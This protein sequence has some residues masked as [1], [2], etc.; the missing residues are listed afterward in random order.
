MFAGRP[1]SGPRNLEHSKRFWL[2]ECYRLGS[3]QF[4]QRQEAA[5]DLES[6][7]AL[8]HEFGESCPFADPALLKQ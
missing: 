5:D 1:I 7:G 3:E 2:L 4:E 6:V 8:C